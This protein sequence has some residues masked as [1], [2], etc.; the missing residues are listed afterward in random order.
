MIKL[1]VKSN[2]A[3]RHIQFSGNMEDL[4]ALRL[5]IF[6]K[7][8]PMVTEEMTLSMLINMGLGMLKQYADKAL[9]V[10]QLGYPTIKECTGLTL[11]RPS[12][13][14]HDRY[15][16]F[17][18]DLGVKPAEKD[19]DLLTKHANIEKLESSGNDR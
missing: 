3:S 8:S 16:V 10:P 12:I 19:C 7:S 11:L 17:S 18:F 2:D 9:E 4:K 15:I 13:N 14:I 6:K 1:N 5:K